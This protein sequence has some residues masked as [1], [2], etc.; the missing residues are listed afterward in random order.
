MTYDEFLHN[1]P[2]DNVVDLTRQRAKRILSDIAELSPQERYNKLKSNANCYAIS[3]IYDVHGYSGVR[4]WIQ[5][6]RKGR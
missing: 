5:L 3:C 4:E 6:G 1:E 2:Q